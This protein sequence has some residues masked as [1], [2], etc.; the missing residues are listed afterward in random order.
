MPGTYASRMWGQGTALRLIV[1]NQDKIV[2]EV[3][4]AEPLRRGGL[5]TE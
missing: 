4:H 2:E 1:L 3:D 5:Y